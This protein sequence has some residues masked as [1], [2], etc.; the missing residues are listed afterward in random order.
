M[1]YLAFAR[2]YRPQT[3]KEL[4]GQ[5]HIVKMLQN[6]IGLNRVSHAYLFAGLKG[7]GKTTVARLL[8]KALNCQNGPTP[9]PC[10]TCDSCI[11]RAKGFREAGIAD[12]LLL[13]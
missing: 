8:A 12:P 2:K 3:F 7:S 11:L 10:G 13:A 4:V 1:S 9:E 6:A 5:K